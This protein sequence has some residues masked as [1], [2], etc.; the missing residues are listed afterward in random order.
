MASAIQRRTF[1]Q[2][3]AGLCSDP[4]EMAAVFMRFRRSAG[5]PVY[6]LGTDSIPGFRP[7][8]QER[9]IGLAQQGWRRQYPGPALSGW[10]RRR[11]DSRRE[12]VQ[13]LSLIHISEPTR[14][15]EISYAVF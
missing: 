13:I 6:W 12:S 15:A 8:G 2:T 5:R 4:I 10:F 9:P 14:Q 3:A 1:R 7:M 11:G